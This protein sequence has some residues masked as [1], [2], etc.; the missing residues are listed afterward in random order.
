MFEEGGQRADSD[1]GWA[2]IA[3]HDKAATVIDTLLRLDADETYT[4]T[5]LSEAAGVPLK[6]LYLDGTLEELVTVGLLEKHEADGKETLFSVDNGSEAFEA[7]KAFDAA[8][9]TSGEVDN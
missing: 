7:A 3:N 6:T 5:A 8:A 2:H 9:A 1:T 4:K